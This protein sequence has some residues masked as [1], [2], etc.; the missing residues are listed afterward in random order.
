V[1]EFFTKKRRQYLYSIALVIVPLLIMYDVLDAQA[2]PLWLALVAAVL[3]VAAP[4]AALMNMSPDP[5]EYAGQPE[6]EIEG[7]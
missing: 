2:A 5:S 6:F 4:V 3:G 1:A 7:E